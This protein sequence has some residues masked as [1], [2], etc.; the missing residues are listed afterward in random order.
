[1]NAGAA[2]ATQRSSQRHDAGADG[3]DHASAS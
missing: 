2:P 1:M 3:L